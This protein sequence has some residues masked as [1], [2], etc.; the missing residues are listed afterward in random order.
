MPIPAAPRSYLILMLKPWPA[1]PLVVRCCV[2]Q[3]L[4]RVSK[5]VAN[6]AARCASKVLNRGAQNDSCGAAQILDR[7]ARV[8]ARGATQLPDRGAQ[9]VARSAANCALL[10]VVVS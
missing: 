2:S 9:A 4:N 5:V 7:G 6:G 8:D 10:C 1:A 3:V